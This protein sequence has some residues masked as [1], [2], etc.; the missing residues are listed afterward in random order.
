MWSRND[1][2]ENIVP[3]RGQNNDIN[4]WSPVLWK[5]VSGARVIRMN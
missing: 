1:K 3:Q 5:E 4:W 2:M